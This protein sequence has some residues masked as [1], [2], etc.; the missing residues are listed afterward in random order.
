MRYHVLHIE[1][2]FA[3]E[4]QKDLFDQQLFDLGVDTIDTG[5][6]P[7]TGHADYYIPSELWE[8]NEDAI[9]DLLSSSHFPLGQLTPYDVY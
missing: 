7:Q 5:S 4:W 1:S 9:K 8:Q 2:S 6:E 3:E